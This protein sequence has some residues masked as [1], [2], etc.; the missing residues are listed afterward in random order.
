MP[1]DKLIK[2]DHFLVFAVDLNLSSLFFFHFYSCHLQH[3]VV[4]SSTA[5]IM[6]KYA[7][8]F[9]IDTP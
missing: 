6:L 2:K 8:V 1:E 3:S 4:M 5:S 7:S 9:L